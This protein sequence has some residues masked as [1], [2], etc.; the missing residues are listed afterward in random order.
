MRNYSLGFVILIS[1]ISVMFT[2]VAVSFVLGADLS[3]VYCSV[4]PVSVVI[5]SGVLLGSFVVMKHSRNRKADKVKH[6]DPQKNEEEN[7]PAEYRPLLYKLKEQELYRREMFSEISHEMKTPLTTIRGYAEL[8]EN[9]MVPY[10]D[11]SEIAKK[12]NAESQ[13][14]LTMID[15]VLESNRKKNA[16]V[17]LKDVDMLLTINFIVDR[18]ESVA[19]FKNIT[20]LTEGDSVY[21]NCEEERFEQICYNL[22]E[23]AIK[24]SKENGIVRVTVREDEN[25]KYL[26]VSDNG[27]G[28]SEQDQNRI[29]DRFFRGDPSHNRKVEGSGLGLSIVK[30]HIESMGAEIR[31]QSELGIGTEVLVKFLKD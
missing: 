13:H 28:I 27:I 11:V 25:G 6:F 18:L 4:I 12:M 1:T 31:I 20:V 9:G 2:S 24:Y 23:N 15:R 22:V 8:M 30:H 29:F 17:V 14:L 10:E 5:L 21:L 16:T 26:I 7:I 19:S 3:E